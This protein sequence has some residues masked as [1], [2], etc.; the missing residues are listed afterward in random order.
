MTGIGDRAAY[1]RALAFTELAE[2]IVRAPAGV[3]GDSIEDLRTRLEAA[4]L[5]ATNL[6]REKASAMDAIKS[7]AREAIA[8]AS[9]AA[10]PVVRDLR[11]LAARAALEAAP[12]GI[13]ALLALWWWHDRRA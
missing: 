7:G 11:E 2:R 1:E 9:D 6:R 4:F 12:W 3:S 5:R 13:L 8:A 10:A